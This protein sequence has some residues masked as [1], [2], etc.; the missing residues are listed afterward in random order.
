MSAARTVTDDT[1]LS[2]IEQHEGLAL[3]DV[4]AP[5][6][7]PCR[8]LAP[9]IE[10]LA[11]QYDGRVRVGKL[12]FDANPGTAERFG[13]RSIPTVLFFKNGTLIDEIVGAHPVAAFAVRIERHLSPTAS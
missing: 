2:D 7:A 4:W 12:D 9:T 8:A 6:C 3:V 5:W 1:F 10:A 11:G 13:V